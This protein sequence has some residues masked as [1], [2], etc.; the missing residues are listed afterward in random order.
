MKPVRPTQLAKRDLRE[1]LSQSRKD[2]GGDL[3]ARYGAAVADGLKRIARHPDR[4]PA[5]GDS[6]P[7]LRR[8]RIGRHLVFYREEAD[9]VIV[10]RILHERMDWRGKA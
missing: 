6:H 10:I 9:A 7:G 2:W 3:A 5:V 1:I 8:L 4:F